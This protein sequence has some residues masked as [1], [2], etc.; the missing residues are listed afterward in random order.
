[1]MKRDGEEDEQKEIVMMAYVCIRIYVYIRMHTYIRG[2]TYAYVY[3][4]AY[5]RVHT[6]V[7]NSK[8]P[9]VKPAHR[10][11]MRDEE[12]RMSDVAT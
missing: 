10:P 9:K 12:L 6:T 7:S 3:T 4:W 8:K 1:M 2:H 11:A 5:I